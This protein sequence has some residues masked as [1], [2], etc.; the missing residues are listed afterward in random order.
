MP[1]DAYLRRTYGID[2]A[3]HD[4]MLASQAGC[5]AICRRAPAPGKRLSV[6]HCHATGLVRGLLCGGLSCNHR[7]GLIRDDAEWA[8]AAARYLQLAAIIAAYS[9]PR[10]AYRGRVDSKA[11]RKRIT[12]ARQSLDR[13]SAAYTQLQ[14]ARTNGTLV[15]VT[16]LS[17]G[18]MMAEID[19]GR[20]T[21]EAR[22][23][24]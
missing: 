22:R 18:Q 4:A 14:D 10:D 2:L 12:K 24:D 1:T 3:Q 17:D 6:D 15:D 16:D 7:L 19:R 5:C 9:P 13:K 20:V 8:L 21:G 23:D 11:R